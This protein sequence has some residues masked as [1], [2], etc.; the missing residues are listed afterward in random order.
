MTPDV[1]GIGE[2]AASIIRAADRASDADPLSRIR[3]LDERLHALEAA[4]GI[5]MR[6]DQRRRER[7]MDR[8]GFAWVWIRGRQ[9]RLTPED[10]LAVMQAVAATRS[11]WWDYVEGE[12]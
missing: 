6:R 3:A 5:A 2:A 4:H 7:G 11:A 9:W 12:E 10:I 8:R 1:S